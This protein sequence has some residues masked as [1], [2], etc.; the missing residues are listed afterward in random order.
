[1]PIWTPI[2]R[3]QAPVLLSPCEHNS[4]FSRSKEHPLLWNGCRKILWGCFWEVSPC[5]FLNVIDVAIVQFLDTFYLKKMLSLTAGE[6]PSFVLTRSKPAT[7]TPPGLLTK[8]SWRQNCGC[9]LIYTWVL[10]AEGWWLGPPGLFHCSK[11]IMGC[12]N[13]TAKKIEWSVA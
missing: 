1:M 12:R 10:H 4:I 6:T 13:F 8:V 3:C 9:M 7:P 11:E 2:P 5:L